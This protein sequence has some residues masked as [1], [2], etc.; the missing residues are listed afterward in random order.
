MVSGVKKAS[1]KKKPA[2]SYWSKEKCNCPVCKKSFEREV[3]LSGNGRM[4]A[5]PLSE[6][7]HRT[8]EPSARF[9]RIYPLIYEIGACPNCFAAFLWSDFKEKKL[10]TKNKD[11]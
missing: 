11:I 5:G 2:I 4:I 1:D 6:D 7:L 10:K 3:M 8:F 9:G